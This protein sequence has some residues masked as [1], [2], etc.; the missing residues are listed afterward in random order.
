MVAAPA[1]QIADGH[2]LVAV[3]ASLV[4]AGTERMVTAFA[5]KSLLAKARARPDLVQQVRAKIQRDGLRATWAAVNARLDDPLPL[6][7]SAAGEVLEVGAGLEGRFRPGDRV[8]IGGAG[9]ANHAEVDLVPGNLAAKLPANVPF[10]QGCFATLGAIALHSVRLV[11]PQLGEWVGIVGTGLVGLLAVQFA[12]NAG[13]RVFAF[14]YDRARLALAKELAAER[15]WCLA[16]GDP[17]AAVSEATESLGC[18]AVVLAAA[19]DKP[20]PFE[21][22]AAIARDRAVVCMVGIS[23]TAFPYRAF[24]HKELSIVVARSY[25]PGRYDPDYERRGMAYPEGYVRW[26]ETENLK[27]VVRL[28]GELRLDVECLTTHRIAFAEAASAYRMMAERREP[29]LGIVLDYPARD[30]AAEAP[31]RPVPLPVTRRSPGACV[32]GVLGAGRFARTIM[33]PRLA[34]LPDVRLKTVASARGLTAEMARGRFGFEQCA[35]D[36]AAVLD[37]PEI[38]AVL[39]FTPHGTHAQFGADA[40]AAGKSVYV[41]KP[42]ALS[43]AQL[44]QVQAAREAS[45]GFL[46]VGFNRRFAPLAQELVRRLSALEGRRQIVIRV[47]AGAADPDSWEADPEQGSGRLLGEACHFVDLAQFLAGAPIVAV[48]AAAAAAGGS[49]APAEDFS[50]H[51][52]FCDGSLATIAYTTFGDTAY[53]KES[54]E[55]FSAGQTFCI[56]DFR[57]LSVV[58]NGKTRR[59]RGRQDKGHAAALAAF[60]DAVRAG[61]A[62]PVA[63]EAVFASSLATLALRESLQS[64]GRIS[65]A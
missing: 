22:A 10:E 53:S 23:G 28:L 19:T 24:M 50:A 42:L 18:D 26:T 12:R 49:G 3:R 59:Q 58:R 20:E 4:S 64:D 55:V 45:E 48:Q 35:S 14:D 17:A 41:E 52:E 54:V 65:L 47:N 37:D 51:M 46:Q 39:V 16:D 2:L 30:I 13:A 34:K 38:N 60:A 21:T 62:A 61:G 1:P 63:E 5:E 31:R 44:D 36:A 29:H 57:A 9:A 6:G 43:R 56:D 33:L 40:L 11:R 8:A 25:G 27:T 7:Y 15:V 32:I